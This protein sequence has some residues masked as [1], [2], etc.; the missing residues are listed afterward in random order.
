MHTL[1]FAAADIAPC[2][3]DVMMV[4]KLA[5]GQGG[6]VCK[7]MLLLTIALVDWMNLIFNL[8]SLV[9]ISNDSGPTD[10]NSKSSTVDQCQHKETIEIVAIA[11][12]CF[13]VARVAFQAAAF[14]YMRA[15]RG[16]LA[17]QLDRNSMHGMRWTLGLVNS[18]QTEQALKLQQWRD[19]F[20]AL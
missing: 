18:I 6:S 2:C 17:R 19:E 7:G 4:P 10:D 8:M 13:F 9:Y 16:P 1:L 3:A 15:S 12:I 14:L 20:Q 11:A 5:H